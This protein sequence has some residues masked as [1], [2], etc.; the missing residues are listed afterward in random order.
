MEFFGYGTNRTGFEKIWALKFFG[1]DDE[2]NI[3]RSVIFFYLS[4]LVAV[5]SFLIFYIL[6]TFVP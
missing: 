3:S 6:Q 2:I 1:N 5:V 4:I